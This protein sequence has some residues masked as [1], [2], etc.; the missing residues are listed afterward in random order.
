MFN[1]LFKSLLHVLELG[2][3]GTDAISDAC[4]RL[5]YFICF[6]AHRFHGHVDALFV[7]NCEADWVVWVI[8]LAPSGWDVESVIRV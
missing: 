4:L 6:L 8:S 3:D 5:G 2:C 1:C 7:C